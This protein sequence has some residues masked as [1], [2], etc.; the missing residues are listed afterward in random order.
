LMALVDSGEFKIVDSN[1]DPSLPL[2]PALSRKE[3]EAIYK[4][5]IAQCP[6]VRWK[7]IGRGNGPFGVHEVSFPPKK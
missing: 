5:A 2:R 7:I 6:E 3:A 1:D 4:L